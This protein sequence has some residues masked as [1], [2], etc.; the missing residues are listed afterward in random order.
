MKGTEMVLE[1]SMSCKH[2]PRLIARED[3]I[4]CVIVDCKYNPLRVLLDS[5][6]Y[7]SKLYQVNILYSNE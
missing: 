4:C 7:L 3:F 1:T 5:M 6:I 2:L